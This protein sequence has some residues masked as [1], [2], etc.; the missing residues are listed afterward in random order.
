MT[1]TGTAAQTPK[2]VH[3]AV[4]VADVDTAARFYLDV[5]GMRELARVNVKNLT[6]VHMTDGNV[7]LSVVQ[8]HSDATAESRVAGPGPCIHHLG[9]E[10]PDPERFWE[11]LQT[12]GCSPVSPPGEIPIK[13]LMPDGILAEIVQPNYF[14]DRFDPP[15]NASNP[16]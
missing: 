13:F 16:A 5:M 2:I 9:M 14:R 12:Q 11:F 6:A 15:A 10:V 3:M 1:P 4:R 7:Y 8:Y